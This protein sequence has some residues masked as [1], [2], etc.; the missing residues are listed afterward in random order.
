MTKKRRKVKTTV[1]VSFEGKR[2]L[3]FFEYLCDLF[4]NDKT[5]HINVDDKFGGDSDSI[6][7]RAIKKSSYDKSFAWFD[8]DVKLSPEV[9]ESL[10]DC[11]RQKFDASVPDKDLQKTYNTENRNPILIV[12]NP[13]AFEGLILSLF[14]IRLDKSADTKK[15]K[16]A[17]DG[18]TKC[19]GDLEK[20]KDFYKK[21][22]PKEKLEN[23]NNDTIALILSIFKDSE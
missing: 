7:E 20:E 8:E 13:R 11:W 3:S 19:G 16:N 2:E 4:Y 10:E 6:V 9:R 21:N 22:L 1:S 5:R 18:H 23:S 17:F 15:Y 12:S 14:N